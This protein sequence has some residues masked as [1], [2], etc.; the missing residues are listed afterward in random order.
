[1]PGFLNNKWIVSLVISAII[2]A[3]ALFIFFKIF[4]NQHIYL[5]ID[6]V[7][8]ELTGAHV[9]SNNLKIGEVVKALK[10]DDSENQVFQIRFDQAIHIPVNSE[11][12]IRQSILDSSCT[13][14]LTLIPSRSYYGKGD[15]IFISAESL[16]SLPITD[17]LFVSDTLNP[18]SES[19]HTHKEIPVEQIKANTEERKTDHKEIVFMVQLLASKEP[20]DEK[21]P[22]FKG[23]DTIMMIEEDGWYKYFTGRTESFT[24]ASANRER[25]TGLGLMDVFVV[26]YQGSQRISVNEAISLKK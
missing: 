16:D 26:A 15:T 3:A 5:K 1:M 20:V 2:I 11:I 6:G 10:S 23:I 22:R 7:G 4:G 12:K 17:G 21:S 24:D 13:V 18:L 9:I 19:A 25:I 8:C 14:F